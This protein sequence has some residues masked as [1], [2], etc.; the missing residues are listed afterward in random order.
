MFLFM[1][2][3]EN[4]SH[5]T[6]YELTYNGEVY[7]SSVKSCEKDGIVK[8]NYK[9]QIKV[10]NNPDY[11]K[12]NTTIENLNNTQIDVKYKFENQKMKP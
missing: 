3:G 9:N 11:H 7:E 6:F 8:F 2:N 4:C 1:R 10:I 5:I 12:A